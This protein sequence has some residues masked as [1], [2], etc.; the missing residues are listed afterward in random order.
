[1]TSRHTDPSVSARRALANAILTAPV[2]RLPATRGATANEIDNLSSSEAYI[3]VLFATYR[4]EMAAIA[5]K[6]GAPLGYDH[7]A[8]DAQTSDFV[9]DLREAARKM[10][11]D[12]D[13]EDPDQ[14]EYDRLT[15]AD[16]GVGHHR[17]GGL[18]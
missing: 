7:K 9:T 12:E 11:A 5:Q 15:A 4:E 8:V 13:A 16:Y 10:S 14:G 17:I 2:T 3:D 18:W 6:A 1:M